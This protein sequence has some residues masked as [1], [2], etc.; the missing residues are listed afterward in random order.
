M[1]YFN[2]A[3]FFTLIFSFWYVGVVSADTYGSGLY[4]SGLY[5]VTATPTPTTAQAT[6]SSTSSSGSSS[7]SGSAG[8][9]QC[10]N[11]KPT[12]AP[13]LFQIDRYKDSATLYFAPAGNPLTYYYVAYGLSS[14]NQERYGATFTI[15]R[16][17]G[18][19]SATITHLS[20]SLGYFFKVRGGNGCMPG[21]WSK[22]MTAKQ[23]SA[24][25]SKKVSYYASVKDAVVGY[26]NNVVGYS[27]NIVSNITKKKESPQ[28]Y[29]SP[30]PIT[31]PFSPQP[32]SVKKALRKNA[33]IEPTSPPPVQQPVQKAPI[34]QG[35]LTQI[36]DKF[37]QSLPCP[38]CK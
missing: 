12:H 13:D 31:T 15:A 29:T 38:W 6:T 18:V 3:L 11:Q 27:K 4:G 28:P 33:L 5:S 34:N 17:T 9:P 35:W 20:P 1:K 21:D 8:K 7:G 24:I 10:S 25:N 2:N 37:L 32:T 23:N 26:T 14:D 30:G 22:S 19:I 16:N 36:V